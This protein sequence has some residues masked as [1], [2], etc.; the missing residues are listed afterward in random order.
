MKDST[1]AQDLCVNRFYI[2]EKNEEYNQRKNV[3]IYTQNPIPPMEP[4]VERYFDKSGDMKIIQSQQR[5][6]VIIT[7]K[8]SNTCEFCGKIFM[9][10]SNLTV[11]RRSHTGEKPYK[12]VVCQYSCAQSSK[13]TRHMKTHVSIG[14]ARLCC[15]FC[16]ANF[17]VQTTLEKHMR[18]CSYSTQS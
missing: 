10:T 14:T 18:I 8:P 12:C 3:P 9:N 7:N 1:E 11:H 16:N 6:N 5:K 13:L 2:Y 4:S 15:A 17:A